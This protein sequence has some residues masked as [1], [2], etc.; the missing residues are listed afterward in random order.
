[1]ENVAHILYGCGAGAIV[2][3][4]YC[5]IASEVSLKGRINSTCDKPKQ[6]AIERDEGTDNI[7]NPINGLILIFVCSGCRTYESM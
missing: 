5:L 7:V 1:M 4:T 2:S 3:L 6:I